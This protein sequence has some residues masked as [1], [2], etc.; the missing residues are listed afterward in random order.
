MIETTGCAGVAIGRGAML[1]PWIFRKLQQTLRAGGNG[2]VAPGV[3]CAGDDPSAEEQLEFLVSH[4]HLMTQ[5]HG[6]YSCRMFRKFAA[7]YGARLG[8][9]EDLEARLRLFESPAEFD[10][11]VEQIRARHGERVSRIATAL[12]K[13]P[14]GPVE[15]W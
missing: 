15:H 6:D 9:P 13:V 5:Q 7:W 2:E 1:D 14:N 11:I 10:Q 8:I 4:F 12:V 3:D